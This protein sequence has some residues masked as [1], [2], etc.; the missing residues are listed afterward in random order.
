MGNA[1]RVKEAQMHMI[2]KSSG[3]AV[4]WLDKIEFQVI[5]ILKIR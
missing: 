1:S 2:L 4:R 5:K 3:R